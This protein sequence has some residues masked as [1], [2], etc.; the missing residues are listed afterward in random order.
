MAAREVR[1]STD[2]RVHG[3]YPFDGDRWKKVRSLTWQEAAK[4]AK[5]PEA[6]IKNTSDSPDFSNIGKTT[7]Y[8]WLNKGYILLEPPHEGLTTIQAAM[9]EQ[10]A[11]GELGLPLKKGTQAVYLHDGKYSLI[12]VV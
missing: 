3:T 6:V 1:F 8:L 7:K 2:V 11:E 5:I 10:T 12:E 4:L 9:M